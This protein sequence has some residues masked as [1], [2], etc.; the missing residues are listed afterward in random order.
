MFRREESQIA[1][2]HEIKFN[3]NKTRGGSS[4]TFGCGA[5]EDRDSQFHVRNPAA[6]IRLLRKKR[7]MW[8]AHDSLAQH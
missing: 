8:Q 5:K 2:V 7:N 3:S 6:Y 1:G 4:R